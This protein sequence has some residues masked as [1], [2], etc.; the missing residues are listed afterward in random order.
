MPAADLVKNNP[1]V[2]CRVRVLLP[3]GGGRLFDLPLPRNTAKQRSRGVHRQ[4][5]SVREVRLI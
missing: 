5:I 2:K 3:S 1:W 4:V